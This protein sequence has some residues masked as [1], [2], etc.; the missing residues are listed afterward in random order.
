MV[1]ISGPGAEEVADSM[2]P[3]LPTADSAELDH[4]CLTAVR[5][6]YTFNGHVWLR[7]QRKGFGPSA[8]AS[9]H[10]LRR[11]AASEAP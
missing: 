7:P 1:G 2:P 10:R 4:S 6:R 3:R 9:L 5:E 11:D 8:L